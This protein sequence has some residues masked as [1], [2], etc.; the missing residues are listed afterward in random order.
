MSVLNGA[1]TAVPTATVHAPITA[2]EPIVLDTAL[3]PPTAVT[4]HGE[5]TCHLACIPAIDSVSTRPHPEAT[6]DVTLDDSDDDDSAIL[7]MQHMLFADS[8]P[9]TLESSDGN[10]VPIHSTEN[11]FVDGDAS[12]ILFWPDLLFTN[13]CDSTLCHDNGEPSPTAVNSDVITDSNISQSDA[14]DMDIIF[15]PDP[16]FVSDGENTPAAVSVVANTTSWATIPADDASDILFRPDLMFTA[17]CESPVCC[18]NGEASPPEV[19]FN[20]I[21]VFDVPNPNK[22]E[23]DPVPMH[24]PL[25]A[26]GTRSVLVTNDARR[27][28]SGPLPGEYPTAPGDHGPTDAA[29]ADSRTHCKHVRYKPNCAHNTVCGEPGRLPVAQLGPLV[30]SCSRLCSHSFLSHPPCSLGYSGSPPPFGEQSCPTCTSKEKVDA[31]PQ[32]VTTQRTLAVAKKGPEQ[33][34]TIDPNTVDA[35]CQ[36]AACPADYSNGLSSSHN[37]V[38][39]LATHVDVTLDVHTL[40]SACAPKPLPKVTYGPTLLQCVNGEPTVIGLSLLEP[41]STAGNQV[42]IWCDATTPVLSL[43]RAPTLFDSLSDTIVVGLSQGDISKAST[44]E[45]C[46]HGTSNPSDGSLG[47]TSS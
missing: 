41:T 36:L 18:N 12:D 3:D 10:V 35:G 46:D 47:S 9:T 6:T 11:C 33:G 25:F 7:F 31:E 43:R 28:I 1:T 22:E 16:L 39:K 34:L 13:N 37:G 27:H 20:T 29:V 17:A 40:A 32:S 21:T 14:E 38:P 42:T 8:E 26:Q 45:H 23:L 44:K 30:S 4:T 15:M 19:H 2:S 5:P 24:D